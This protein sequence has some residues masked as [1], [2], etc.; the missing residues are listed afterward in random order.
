MLLSLAAIC[1]PAIRQEI[2]NTKIT[3]RHHEE[4]V[5]PK[6]KLRITAKKDREP[7]IIREIPMSADKDSGPLKI[8]A[9]KAT[10][11]SRAAKNPILSI[12]LNDWE[13]IS[14]IYRLT[15]FSR[16]SKF[17]RLL[18]SSF[19]KSVAFFFVKASIT[20]LTL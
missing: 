18:S 9:S 2:A 13:R 17:L 3:Q 20:K 12:V 1:T 16:F 6:N 15:S 19:F 11:A 10:N 14:P 5:S 4:V 8:C 7:S